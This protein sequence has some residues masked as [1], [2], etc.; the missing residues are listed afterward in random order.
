A[1][2]TGVTS[3]HLVWLPVLRSVF[4]ARYSMM[5]AFL[6]FFAYGRQRLT[7]C[8]WILIVWVMARQ[9]TLWLRPLPIRARAL[10]IAMAGQILLA[11]AGGSFGGL[12]LSWASRPMPG[13]PVQV[14]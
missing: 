5:L 9:N 2:Q 10:L 8:F 4:T 3:P 7:L 12:Y 14:L 11:L 1:R 6:L 13:L